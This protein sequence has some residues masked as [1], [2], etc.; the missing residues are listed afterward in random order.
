[1]FA[2]CAKRNAACAAKYACFA[3]FALALVVVKAL[4]ALTCAVAV[5]K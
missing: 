5:A 4:A 3:S 2:R 1:M